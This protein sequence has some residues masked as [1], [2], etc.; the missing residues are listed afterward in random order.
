V[1]E[2]HT[3]ERVQ[4]LL[5]SHCPHLTDIEFATTPLCRAELLVEIEGVAALNRQA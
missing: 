1:T 4:A 3:A 2:A 5:A